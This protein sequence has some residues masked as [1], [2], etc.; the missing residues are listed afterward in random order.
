MSENRWPTL[1]E[2]GKNDPQA[3][4]KKVRYQAELDDVKATQQA[5][6]EREKASWANEYTLRQA[7]LNAYVEV[8]KGQIERSRAGAQ[9]VQTAAAAISGAYV[10]ILGLSFAVSDELSSP[11]PARGIAPTIFLGLSIALTTVY[12]AYLTKPKEVAGAV[13]Q[14]LLY[15]MQ[16]ERR[17]AF[18]RWTKATV[19]ARVKWLQS[20]VVSLA[21]GVAFLPV[22]YLPIGNIVVWILVALGVGSALLLPRLLGE[23]SE[24]S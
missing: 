8:A 2:V 3:E 19:L 16:R 24:E 23:Q 7:D 6:I 13:P 11:L 20:A 14:D 10:A 18:I 17:D 1:P 9:F 21:L 5:D 22:A 15:E 12:L 4:V